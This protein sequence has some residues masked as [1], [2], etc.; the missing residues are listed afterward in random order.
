ML[1]LSVLIGIVTLVWY[2]AIPVLLWKILQELRRIQAR[3]APSAKDKKMGRLEVAKILEGFLEGTGG[4]WDWDDFISVAEVADERLKQI[5]QHVN[6]LSEQFPPDKRGEYCNEQGR[7][8]IRRY[9]K[10]LRRS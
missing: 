2:I 4:D 7:E 10:E 5:Q 1:R 6:L 9:I 3:E 8:V